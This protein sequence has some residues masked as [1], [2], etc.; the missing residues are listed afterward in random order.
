MLQFNS[1]QHPMV[2][3]MDEITRIASN[4]LKGQITTQMGF[5]SNYTIGGK[6]P[7]VTGDLVSAVDIAVP[8]DETKKIDDTDELQKQIEKNVLSVLDFGYTTAM[9]NASNMIAA[10]HPEDRM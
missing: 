2:R 8:L 5:L 6:L 7:S 10:K 1:R 9:E 3:D 4:T